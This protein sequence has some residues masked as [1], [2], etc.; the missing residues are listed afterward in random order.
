M[1]LVNKKYVACKISLAIA[2]RNIYNLPIKVTIKACVHSKRGYF[3]KMISQIKSKIITLEPLTSMRFFAA[4]GVVFAHYGYDYNTGGIGVIFFFILSG[5]I[6]AYNY[7]DNF[8]KISLSP[9]NNFYLSRLARI[10]PIHFV[11]FLISIPLTAKEANYSITDTLS[12]ILLI[13]TWYPKISNIFSYNGV[14]WTLSCELFF[15]IS[16]PFILYGSHRFKLSTTK[17]GITFLLALVIFSILI[18]SISIGG[19]IKQYSTE[20]WYGETSPFSN[21]LN[22][23]LGIITC[24]I[25]RKTNKTENI[26]T[27]YAT[28]FEIIAILI[29]FSSYFFHRK[30]ANAYSWNETIFFAPSI[31]FIIFVFSFNKGAISKILSHKKLLHLGEI[32]FSMYMIHQLMIRYYELHVGPMIYIALDIVGIIKQIAFS[33][34]IVVAAHISYRVIEMPSRLFIKNISSRKKGTKYN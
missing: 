5:F 12:N 2:K 4:A 28:I 30:M 11:T 27:T 31:M 17:R 13:H 18:T 22:F 6:L 10:Y 34:I 25:F 15:Y 9:L 3:P 26:K 33:I 7:N 21:I 23:T 29:F 16:L 24:F 14:S 8:K 32:S 1:K 20:W 19:F